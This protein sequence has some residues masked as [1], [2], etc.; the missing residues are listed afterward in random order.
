MISFFFI[1]GRPRSPYMATLFFRPPF[2]LR[3]H[4]DYPITNRPILFPIHY[5]ISLSTKCFLLPRMKN[6]LALILMRRTWKGPQL[7]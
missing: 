1:F 5:S 4:L 7:L 3:S 2:H 6:V